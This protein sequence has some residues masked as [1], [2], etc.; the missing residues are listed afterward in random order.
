[1]ATNLASEGV[2]KVVQFNRL[3]IVAVT[4]IRNFNTKFAIMRL[5]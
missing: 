1:M 2:L 3:P 5:V 4:K